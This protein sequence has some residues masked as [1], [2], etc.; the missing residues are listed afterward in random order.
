[1]RTLPGM[2]WVGFLGAAITLDLWSDLSSP[3][4]W[5]LGRSYGRP[6]DFLHFTDARWSLLITKRVCRFFLNLPVFVQQRH[7]LCFKVAQLTLPTV[8]TVHN[9]T[10]IFNDVPH[11]L[12]TPL[13]ARAASSIHSG[14]KWYYKSRFYDHAYVIQLRTWP[15]HGRGEGNGSITWRTTYHKTAGDNIRL[16]HIQAPHTIEMTH[17]YTPHSSFISLDAFQLQL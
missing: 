15:V 1:M 10:L 13:I 11:C 17:I 8:Q 16:T 2:I 7:T 5:G 9:C 14:H 12:V 3:S 6:K 4:A